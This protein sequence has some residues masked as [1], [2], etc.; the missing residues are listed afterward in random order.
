MI[1][2]SLAQRTIPFSSYFAEVLAATGTIYLTRAAFYAGGMGFFFRKPE[3]RE[4]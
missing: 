1:F 3:V 2:M 4:D